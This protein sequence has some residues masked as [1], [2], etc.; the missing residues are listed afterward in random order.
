MLAK[1]RW[2]VTQMHYLN[3]FLNLDVYVVSIYMYK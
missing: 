3:Q 2:K 1:R